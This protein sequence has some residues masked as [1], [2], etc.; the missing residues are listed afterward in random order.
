MLERTQCLTQGSVRLS[1]IRRLSRCTPQCSCL[2]IK[3]R[4]IQTNDQR[5]S[6]DGDANNA[7]LMSVLQRKVA[8]QGVVEDAEAATEIG[9]YFEEFRLTIPLVVRWGEPVKTSEIDVTA[10]KKY[11][12]DSMVVDRVVESHLNPFLRN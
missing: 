12:Q 10:F 9:G 8:G 1:P 5:I 2:Q 6:Y 7:V 4:H 11:M 3:Y